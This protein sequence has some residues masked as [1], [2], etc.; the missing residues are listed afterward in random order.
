M[1][2]ADRVCPTAVRTPISTEHTAV[3]KAS[4]VETPELEDGVSLDTKGGVA[5]AVQNDPNL[6]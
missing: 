1:A 3:M 4:D 2:V 6:R 5:W